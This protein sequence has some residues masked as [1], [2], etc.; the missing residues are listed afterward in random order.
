MH[1]FEAPD[2]IVT[3]EID[4]ETGELATPGCPK[5]PQRSVHRRDA[6]GADLP[7]PR[8]RA[9]TLVSGWEPVQPASPSAAATT[10]EGPAEVAAVQTTQPVQIARPAVA[11]R[12]IP[13]TPPQAQQPEAPK[14]KGFFGRLKDVFK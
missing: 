5:S 13:V 8:Q 2:G 6:A 11:P 9:R 12:S 7:H 10:T 1:A 3:A 14:K 4:A